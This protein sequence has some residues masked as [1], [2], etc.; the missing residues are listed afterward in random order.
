[1]KR[2]ALLSLLSLIASLALA[3]VP[4]PPSPPPPS[5]QTIAK[6][7]VDLRVE[8]LK[9]A[10]NLSD[11]EAADQAA[12]ETKIY[13]S[14]DALEHAFSS[15][16]SGYVVER[17]PTYQ[18]L[19]YFSGQIERQKALDLVDPSLRRYLKL[20]VTKENREERATQL[21]Q[22]AASLRAKGLN[23]SLSYDFKTDSVE[24]GVPNSTDEATAAAT[25]PEN[26]RSRARFGR[27][28]ADKPK[29]GPA[30]VMAGDTVTGGWALYNMSGGKTNNFCTFGFN[31]KD[32]YGQ[33]AILTAG[34]CFKDVRNPNVDTN[35]RFL[36][37]PVNEVLTGA[38]AGNQFD[39]AV[40][41]VQGMD[42][43]PYV[44]TENGVEPYKKDYAYLG[45][46]NNR[47]QPGYV[48]TVSGYT[49]G[50]VYVVGL[51]RQAQQGQGMSI[52]KEGI[53]T[54]MTCG[55]IRTQYFSDSAVTN[56]V[57]A[58]A[59]PQSYFVGGGDSGGPVF[60]PPDANRY[61]YALGII[62][63]GSDLA[64][65]TLTGE[66]LKTSTN[67]CSMS[68]IP[69]DRVNDKTPIDLKIYPSGTVYPG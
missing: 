49:G 56:A 27:G 42:A 5:P 61:V 34:H 64:H 35:N 22:I 65:P 6:V 2:F 45:Y 66:C 9:R 16:Y 43:G 18:V 36:A 11:S 53:F 23:F 29:T 21:A 60:T 17:N 58:H 30:G 28:G 44:W 55:V 41:G 8:T 59:S 46:Y 4:S 25:L 3:Q 33:S 1:M 13:Q 14:I 69:I 38:N 19:V 32:S 10:F 67:V 52:C 51:Y 7:S 47:F 57:Q 54:G 20:A 24:V 62:H 48:N 31:M 37:L 63:G 15:Q 12:L 26:W 39:H 40:M 50:Y 68:Y